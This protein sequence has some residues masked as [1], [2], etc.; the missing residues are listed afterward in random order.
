MLANRQRTDRRPSSAP[1]FERC[2][3]KEKF[4][5]SIGRQLF[6]IQRFNN[7][8]AL[9]HQQMHMHRH[10]WR[11]HFLECNGVG[12]SG[13]NAPFA[14][15]T[16]AFNLWSG[17]RGRRPRA[18]CDVPRGIVPIARP[19]S[20]DE[21]DIA[22]LDLRARSRFQ[23]FR[24]NREIRRQRIHLQMPRDI[25]QHGSPQNRCDGIYRVFPNSAGVTLHH[26]GFRSAEKFSAAGKMT[27]RVDVRADV[28]AQRDGIR[29]RADAAFGYQIAMLLGKSEQKRRMS[30]KV[31]HPDE[32]GLREIVD[33]GLRKLADLFQ[34]HVMRGQSWPA[35]PLACTRDGECAAWTEWNRAM[36]NGPSGIAACSQPWHW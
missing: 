32:V 1:N 30:W 24:R 36:P 12:P 28:T 8:D 7:V 9:F 19:A 4:I 6:Q 22:T 34:R 5:N 11:R 10:A 3:D 33:F 23:M 13:E 2:R 27:E 25:Q 15:P 18:A 21:R 17:A 29:R 16:S 26:S 31:R 35:T 20:A 14:E